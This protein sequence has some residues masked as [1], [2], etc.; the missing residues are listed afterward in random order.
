M[1]DLAGLSDA[2][3]KLR[4]A[5][6]FPQVRDNDFLTS[7]IQ[8][9][10]AFLSNKEDLAPVIGYTERQA[11]LIWLHGQKHGLVSDEKASERMMDD[12]LATL[13]PDA[14]VIGYSREQMRETIQKA[15]SDVASFELPVDRLLATTTAD[16]IAMRVMDAIKKLP[17]KGADSQESASKN[18]Y[19][20]YQD[21]TEES[22]ATLTPAAQPRDPAKL[23]EALRYVE[24]LDINPKTTELSAQERIV[25]AARKARAALAEWNKGGGDEN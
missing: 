1:S 19:V 21:G 17:C 2:I 23:V 4:V 13:T 15:I 10:I 22:T 3:K 9:A 5:A 24:L 11:K 16:F 6:G 25:L 12:Y 8:D 7:T 20:A 14:L 18:A